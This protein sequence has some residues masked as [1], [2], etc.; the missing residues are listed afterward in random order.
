MQTCS[1]YTHYVLDEHSP[2]ARIEGA[3]KDQQR[4]AVLHFAQ[5]TVPMNLTV[6]CVSTLARGL[7][8][9]TAKIHLIMAGQ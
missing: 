5:E 3:P 2:P 4:H 7:W 9:I 6:V 8:Q 1:Y